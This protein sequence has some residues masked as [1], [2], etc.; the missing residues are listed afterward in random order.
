MFSRNPTQTVLALVKFCYLSPSPYKNE[1]IK[2]L[3]KQKQFNFLMRI[4]RIYQSAQLSSGLQLILT[5]QATNHVA[6]VLRLPIGAMVTVFNGAGG[7]YLAKIKTITKKEVI[8]ELEKFIPLA[9]ESSLSIHLGQGIS[10]GEKMDWVIQKATE[11]GVHEITPLLSKRCDVKL[12]Q[13]RWDKRL[14]HWQAVAISA[15]EQCGRDKIPV[16]NSPKTIQGWII[17]SFPGI[18]IIFHPYESEKLNGFP[19]HIQQANLLIGPEGGFDESEVE[20]AKQ[21]G[22]KSMA[23]G[24]RILRTETAAMVGIAIFQSYFGDMKSLDPQ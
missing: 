14:Q 5:P 9:V 20:F 18:K 2:F 3:H 11:L 16:I 23:L 4:P 24:P 17:Q 7:E 1:E 8:V 13:D 6:R 10:K 15:C 19:Q 22:F 21:N 12:T